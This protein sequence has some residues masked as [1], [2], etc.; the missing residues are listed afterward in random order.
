MAVCNNL[1]SAAGKIR[2][3]YSPGADDILT[4]D[5]WLSDKSMIASGNGAIAKAAKVPDIW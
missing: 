2:H 1:Q 3:T 4:K 5:H